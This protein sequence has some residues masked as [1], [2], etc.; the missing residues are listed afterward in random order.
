M[1][2]RKLLTAT[3]AATLL[4]SMAAC[5]GSSSGDGSADISEP[6]KVMADVIP[7]AELIREAEDLGL[8]GDVKVDITEISGD[9]DVNQLTEAGDMDANFFQ[10]VPYLDDWNANHEGSDLVAVAT[11]HVEPLGLYS[12]K[13]TS[14][15]DVPD[16][17]V[18]A[19][20][21]DAT[22]QARG[23]FLLEDAGLLTL[24]VNR[25]D[26]DLDYSQV[27]DADVSENP[28]NISFIKIDRPQL[29]A[30][31]DD[32][33]VTLSIVNGNYALEAG[34]IPSD[35]SL[36]LETAENNPY[37]NVLVTKETLKD[38]PR[39]QKLAEALESPELAQFITDNY[40]GSV[41]P[42]TES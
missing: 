17:A 15:D 37:A 1:R 31:L 28:K 19:I 41:L 21:A 12:K 16:G 14:L 9:V 18:I 4:T 13:L 35:D 10:H 32:P 24:D 26:P 25:D 29:A 34:L 8:L 7:H 38:D 3:V 6:L 5:G 22:N 2:L 39:V 23:L 27:T 40:Q 42:A 30:S 36:A 20:P 33:G 11:V